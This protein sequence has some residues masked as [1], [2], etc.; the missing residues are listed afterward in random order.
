MGSDNEK[1]VGFDLSNI[2][3]TVSPN[4]NFYQYA[5]GNWIKNNP[6]PDDQTRWGAFNVLIEETNDQVKDYY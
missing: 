4:D 3:S 6:V 1:V 2:D 5:V